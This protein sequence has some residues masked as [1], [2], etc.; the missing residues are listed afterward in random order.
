[1]LDEK[2]VQHIADLARLKLTKAEIKKYQK[3]LSEILDYVG[4]LEKVDT[5]KIEPCTGGTE[6][7][8][9]TREDIAQEADESRREKLLNQ[10][11]IREKDFIKTKGVFE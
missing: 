6:L 10:A 1:M 7:K 5:E 3:Q 8:N 4:Q 9:V 11:P 2:E